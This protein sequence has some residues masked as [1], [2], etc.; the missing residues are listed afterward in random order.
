M[1]SGYNRDPFMLVLVP[2]SQS[3]EG[4]W[5]RQGEAEAIGE[6]MGEM[7]GRQTRGCKKAI[8]L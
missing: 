2:I 8:A 1:V 6:M 5:R 4:Q 7:A 3:I